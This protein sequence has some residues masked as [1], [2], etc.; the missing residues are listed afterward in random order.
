MMGVAIVINQDR[1]VVADALTRGSV[2][3]R[4]TQLNQ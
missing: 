4:R 1:N 3:A 2:N